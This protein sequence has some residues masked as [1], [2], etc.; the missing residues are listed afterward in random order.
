[1]TFSMYFRFFPFFWSHCISQILESV[2]HIHQH[3]IVHRDLK[4]SSCPLPWQP[5]IHTHL[6]SWPWQHKDG[7]WLLS[8]FFS[9]SF[10]H[11][12]F[13]P[14]LFPWIPL[15][16]HFY[17]ISFFSSVCY[18][19]SLL[20]CPWPIMCA[21]VRACVFSS[22][23]NIHVLRIAP[24]DGESSPCGRILSL[25]H[26]KEKTRTQANTYANAHRHIDTYFWL[27]W[28]GSILRDEGKGIDE[29]LRLPWQPLWHHTIHGAAGEGLCPKLL[30]GADEKTGWRE[31]PRYLQFS[32]QPT[33]RWQ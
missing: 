11:F 19:Y 10:L 24:R 29:P 3:D 23:V 15:H 6:C 7:S 20:P 22:C 31:L 12:C 17:S 30:I 2:N 32:T 5:C 8:V 16:L 14:L 33:L 4:V 26:G 13:H 25:T 27:L 21:C 1:M 18:Q 9:P 28:K